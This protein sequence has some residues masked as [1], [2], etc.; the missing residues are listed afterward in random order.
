[1]DITKF[2]DKTLEHTIFEPYDTVIFDLDNTI[3]NCS[4]SNG[5][6]MGAY[7]TEPPYKLISIGVLQDIKGNIIE[8]QEGVAEILKILDQ[9]DKNMGI[10]SRGE[11]I[12]RPFDAQPSIMI[13]KKFGLYQ[14]FNY[15]VVLKAGIDKQEYCKPLGTTLFIDDDNTQLQSVM[16]RD[17][18]DVLP[19]QSFQNWNILLMPK[20]EASLRFSDLKFSINVK[21]TINV[22][23]VGWGDDYIPVD[24]MPI[25]EKDLYN[26]DLFYKSIGEAAV[27]S[28]DNMDVGFQQFF[29]R[30][31]WL[32]ET[33]SYGLDPV[34]NPV[35]EAL[36]ANKYTTERERDIQRRPQVI[37]GFLYVIPRYRGKGLAKKLQDFITQAMDN[38][39]G[40]GNYTTDT[41]TES[42]GG[43]S[44]MQ[45]Y[46]SL[47]GNPNYVN[48]YDRRKSKQS[49]ELNYDSIIMS[50]N[51]N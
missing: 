38:K 49:N 36:P 21:E 44:T 18:I 20:K 7:E 27:V 48:I 33:P 41:Y 19:R 22:R 47:Q 42:N 31:I 28:I 10:V 45:Y 30:A 12:N 16:Q 50:L 34:E 17:D 40:R 15:E 26:R 51:F 46:K 43:W 13:L 6:R 4:A 29:S 8:L 23:Y 35:K 32:S 24:H 3:W 37:I 2:L 11:K 5:N 39:F 14:Y 1:M 25:P 9:E